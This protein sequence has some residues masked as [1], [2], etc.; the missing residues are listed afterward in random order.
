MSTPQSITP[1]AYVVEVMAPFR[2]TTQFLPQPGNPL[3]SEHSTAQPGAYRLTFT[4]NDFGDA[5]AVAAV[6]MVIT[7]RRYTYLGFLPWIT[8]HRI[9]RTEE[10][11]WDLREVGVGWPAVVGDD[12][13][14]PV[15]IF[16][17]IA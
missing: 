7:A 1:A 9:P 8:F 13:V 5:I 10:F 11:A 2:T 15:A 17:R 14:T 3:R 4:T 12:D 16:R 6:D